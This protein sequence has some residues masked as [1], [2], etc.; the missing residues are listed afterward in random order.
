MKYRLIVALLAATTLTAC[1]MM[2]GL[3]KAQ[4][5]IVS[6]TDSFSG[7]K[8]TYSS[9]NNVYLDTQ[10]P[11]PCGARVPCALYLLEVAALEVG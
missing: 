6:K 3:P 2:T 7:S 10:I 8:L 4:F 11:N 5:E 1:P 9:N